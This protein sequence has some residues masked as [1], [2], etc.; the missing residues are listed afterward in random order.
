MSIRIPKVNALMF[1][2][3]PFPKPQGSRKNL[4]WLLFLS[5]SCSFFIWLFGPFNIV[6]QT[7]QLYIDLILFSLGLVFFA[8]VA[9]IEFGLPSLVPRFFQRWNLGK[10]ILW[11][12]LEI[13]LVGAIMFFYKS[14]LGGFRD[15]TWAEYFNVIGRVL[16]IGFT[17]SFFI[18]GMASYFG[19]RQ[20]SLLSAR[21][22]YL[23]TAP[24]A[25]P[26]PLNL[27]DILYIVSDDNYVDIHLMVK[28]QRKKEVF[29]SSLKN[30]ETQLV[31]PLSPMLRCHRQYLIN[32]EQV[33]IQEQSSRKMVLRLISYEDEIPVSRT[34]V[35]QIR[36]RLS[37]HP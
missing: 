22:E 18:L 5:L 6:N 1:F 3:T 8:S 20:F 11:Y 24:Q 15:F 23:L 9:L 27:K 13:F 17:V 36:E 16:G 7:G 2:Y 19:R 14:Y 26:L 34:Y 10:A 25:Q 12:S 29:R 33:E 32:L 21:E 28:G 35:D 4:L 30:I 31:H 37:T